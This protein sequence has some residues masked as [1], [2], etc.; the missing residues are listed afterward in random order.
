[1]PLTSKLF[2]L[3]ERVGR[4][5]E[6]VREP[7][8]LSSTEDQH[9][10]DDYEDEEYDEEMMD[11]GTIINRPRP[12]K[13]AK[14]PAVPPR[15]ARRASKGLDLNCLEKEQPRTEEVEDAFDPHQL[16]L[17]SEED[18][19]ES[20]DDYDESLLDL[21]DDDRT[22][23]RTSSL[24]SFE[25]TARVVSFMFVGKPLLVEISIE[26]PKPKSR[27]R[28]RRP[29]PLRLDS[30]SSF[31]PLTQKANLPRQNT[32]P[33]IVSSVA[34]IHTTTTDSET[35]SIAPSFLD[36]DPF[37]PST[38][39]D[40]HPPTTNTT[41][42]K[43]PTTTLSNAWKTGVSRTLSLAKSARRRP[44]I[45]LLNFVGD[46]STTTLT[47]DKPKEKELRASWDS[48]KVMREVE[49]ASVADHNDE[50]EKFD[51]VVRGLTRVTTPLPPLKV[52]EKEEMRVKVK[53]KE[54]KL[55]KSMFGLG[56]RKSVKA[57]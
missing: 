57:A 24:K 21:L 11:D 55:K 17:S 42:L 33:D 34:S 51:D 47:L 26:K 20:A 10:D 39:S 6:K 30:I 45:P 44:S 36:A 35:Q 32:D 38:T 31:R 40:A 15:S 53:T 8:I 46:K 4:D 54:I 9:Y 14:C 41:A 12:K 56:R 13:A 3:L 23:S 25:D 1:M 19:S 16:Y 49:T 28:Q 2:P 50:A 7:E 18:A 48:G 52:G 22:P 43:T 27:Q 37:P 5:N 29:S